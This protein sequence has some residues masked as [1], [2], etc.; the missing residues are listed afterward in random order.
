MD[1]ER[2]IEEL[3]IE[4]L[5]KEVE[6]ALLLLHGCMRG[7]ERITR[8]DAQDN[9]LHAFLHTEEIQRRF[10]FKRE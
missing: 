4:E 5:L 6:L 10:G 3:T 7:K 8:R 9:A 2:T 1:T